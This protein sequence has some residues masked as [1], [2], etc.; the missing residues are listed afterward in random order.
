MYAISGICGVPMDVES[1]SPKRPDLDGNGK[2][3]VLLWTRL[4]YMVL[5]EAP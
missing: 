1:A 2:A 4:G 5:M 3:D